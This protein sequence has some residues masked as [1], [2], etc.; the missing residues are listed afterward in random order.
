MTMPLA[1]PPSHPGDR[2]LRILLSLFWNATASSHALDAALADAADGRGR[3]LLVEGA[4]GTGK[5]ALLLTPPPSARPRTGFVSW[6]PAGPSSSA[7]SRS[8]WPASCWNRRW[9]RWRRPTAPR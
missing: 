9:R 4:A 6:R 2:E 3:S 5:T 1:S 8:A 7:S